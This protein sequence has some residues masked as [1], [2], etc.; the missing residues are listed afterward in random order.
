MTK[1]SPSHPKAMPRRPQGQET[2][3]KTSRNRLRR[4]DNFVALYDPAL[5]Q[6]ETGSFARS[7]FVDLGYGAEPF[8]TVESAARFRRFNATLPVL[9][10]EIDAARVAI[11]QPFADD[12]T[13]FRLGGFNLPLQAGEQV[14]LIRAFNVLRQYEESAVA[15]AYALLA[16]QLLPGGLVVEGTSDPFGRIWVAHL[17]RKVATREE[18]PPEG[19]YSELY[20]EA[21][22]FSTNFRTGF[23]PSEFQTILPKNLIHQ[24]IPDTPI[25]RFFAQWQQATWETIAQ[26]TWG[27]RS[28]F[29]ASAHA[30]AARGYPLDL[31]R[32]WLARGYLVWQRPSLFLGSSLEKPG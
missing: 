4:V 7:L 13:H 9:G 26:R 21:L 6:R 18:T 12:Q 23:D 24:V 8:T 2:R 17:L 22:V 5:L 25:Y 14:R 28:W 10:V 3:G 32:R 29:V 16:R 31:R 30:L 11:A 27:V 19:L 1:A 15:G 20:P